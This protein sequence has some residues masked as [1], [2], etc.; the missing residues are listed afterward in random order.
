MSREPHLPGRAEDQAAARD[1]AR[2]WVLVSDPGRNTLLPDGR[3]ARNP[4]YWARCNYPAL[5]LWDNSR[6]PFVGMA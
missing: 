3:K 5:Y 1:L 6:D 2:A 4:H